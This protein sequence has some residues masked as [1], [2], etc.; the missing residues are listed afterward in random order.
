MIRNPPFRLGGEFVLRSLKV[1]RR[2]VAV[3]A[4]TVFLESVGR[5]EKIFAINRPQ[6]L[7]SF[8]SVCPW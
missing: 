5:Y 2:G 4:R 7:L 1:A 3:L 6:Y 8:A